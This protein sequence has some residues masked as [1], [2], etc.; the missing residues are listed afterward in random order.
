MK[1]I[2][3]TII[4]LIAAIYATAQTENGYFIG[5]DFVSYDGSL[6]RD[7]DVASF[8]ILGHGYAK[9]KQYVYK[10]G[11]IMEYVSPDTFILEDSNNNRMSKTHDNTNEKNEL[12][13][14]DKILGNGN[15]GENEY[16]TANG[17]VTFRGKVVTK[18]DAATLKYLGG[19]YAVDHHHA[20][21]NG[22][23][24]SD[25]WGKNL[26]QYK[27][28]GYATDGVHWYYNGKPVERN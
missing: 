10:D 16:Q 25:A 9:D 1:K 15:D 2:L 24:L 8:I 20:Y 11:K 23:I 4:F 5:K 7:A 28:N 3:F 14:L 21:Y 22:N 18:A 6:L 17:H 19:G 26:F 13:V 12:T 27:G